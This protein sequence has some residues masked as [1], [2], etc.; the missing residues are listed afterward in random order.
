MNCDDVNIGDVN[1]KIQFTLSPGQ[2]WSQQWNFSE[3]SPPNL[4]YTWC[5]MKGVD[6]HLKMITD[7]DPIDVVLKNLTTNQNI[8]FQDFRVHSQFNVE[9]AQ[10]CQFELSVMVQ[11][12]AH[13]A[14]TFS[15]NNSYDIGG[16]IG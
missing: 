5:V 16:L 3:C 9:T 10:G 2:I 11:P 4:R 6:P 1:H 8:P 12:S 7:N 14:I 15:T 13:K